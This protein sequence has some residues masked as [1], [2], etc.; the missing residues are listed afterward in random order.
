MQGNGTPAEALKP[1][2]RR[3]ENG[4][5]FLLENLFE[6]AAHNRPIPCFMRYVQETGIFLCIFNT[7]NDKC[8]SES[9]VYHPEKVTNDR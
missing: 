3:F 8:H 7:L 4:A 2:K 1:N 6:K 9:D 5:F